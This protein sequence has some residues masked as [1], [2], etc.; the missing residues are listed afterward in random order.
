M[1][2]TSISKTAAIRE[3]AGCVSI[4]GAGTSWRV[5]GPY[6]D[7]DPSGPYTERTATSYPQARS[8]ATRWRASVV[9]AL[10]G[11]LTD[12]TSYAVECSAAD[13]GISDLRGILNLAL[14]AWEPE[15]KA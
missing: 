8:I 5:I 11:R 2:M 1:T 15:S 13:R 4:H 10:M 9:L 3:S 12:D 7:S 14:A 6:R